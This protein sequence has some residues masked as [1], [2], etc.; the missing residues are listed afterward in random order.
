MVE[1]DTMIARVVQT[2]SDLSVHA[3]KVK[4]QERLEEVQRWQ[5][6]LKQE[7]KLMSPLEQMQKAKD[8]NT[9]RQQCDNLKEKD[10]NMAVQIEPL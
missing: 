10:E 3:E 6:Q 1:Y 2:W 4:I 9:L 7:M 5:E 8:S